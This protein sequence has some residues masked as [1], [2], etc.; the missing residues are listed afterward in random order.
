MYR[1]S[2]SSYKSSIE[3]YIPGSSGFNSEQNVP[4]LNFSQYIGDYYT[5]NSPCVLSAQWRFLKN[6]CHK[7]FE[8]NIILSSF[9]QNVWKLLLYIGQRNQFK[10]NLFGYIQNGCHQSSSLFNFR[11]NTHRM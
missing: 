5:K 10:A 9:R 11:P 7:A 6:S 3:D 4:K 1:D 8:T 2:P